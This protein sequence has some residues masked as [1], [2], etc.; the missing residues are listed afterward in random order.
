MNHLPVEESPSH[1]AVP[2]DIRHS[3]MMNPRFPL[4]ILDL[5]ETL[6]H[7]SEV[8]LNRTCDFR[9]GPYFA[10]TRPGLKDFLTLVSE[11]FELAVWSSSSADYVSSVLNSIWPDSIPLQFSWSRD[12]C[13]SVYHS[14]YQSYYW[15]KDLRKVKRRGF[16]LK[17]VLIVDDEP[18][19]L[20]RNYGNAIYISPFEGDRSDRDLTLLAGYLNEIAL[21]QDF[22]RLEKRNW[23]TSATGTR[24]SR[25]T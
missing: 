1:F 9:A 6:I 19:K 14:E 15:V 11:N 2:Q 4:L 3:S 10:Y 13:T 20:S 22:R 24:K 8:E 25:S 7:A 5:D 16:D 17:R 18:R 21:S 12:R 23:R